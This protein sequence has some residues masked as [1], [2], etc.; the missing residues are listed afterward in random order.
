[1]RLAAW[2]DV[3]AQRPRGFMVESSNQ[4]SERAI[5]LA[6]GGDPE[7]AVDELVRLVGGDVAILE[8]ARHALVDRLRRRSDDYLATQGLTLIN[9]AFSR[10]GWADPVEW[11]PRK[12]RIRR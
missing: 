4:I 1:M 8:L 9:A 3:L 6:G 11:Q 2:H 7:R 10:I 12:W 5:E